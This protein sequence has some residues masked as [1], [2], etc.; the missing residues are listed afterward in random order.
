MVLEDRKLEDRKDVEA[1]NAGGKKPYSKPKLQV[2][3]DLNTLTRAVHRN[4]K[5][6]GGDGTHTSDNT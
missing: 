3:G 2:Y 1:G 5:Q 6:D 4:T